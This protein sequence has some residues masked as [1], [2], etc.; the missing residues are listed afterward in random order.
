MK[1][2]VMGGADFWIVIDGSG[3]SRLV[4]AFESENLY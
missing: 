2:Y 1:Q 4:D 3:F